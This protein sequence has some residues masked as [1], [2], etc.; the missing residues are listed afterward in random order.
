MGVFTSVKLAPSGQRQ[1]LESVFQARQTVRPVRRFIYRSEQLYAR[2]IANQIEILMQIGK[3]LPGPLLFCRREQY[4][5]SPNP[6][7]LPRLTRVAF[8]AIEVYGTAVRVGGRFRRSPNSGSK[9]RRDHGKLIPFLKETPG[10]APG[11]S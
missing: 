3:P 10:N 4:F 7:K 8:A 11:V 5:H 2:G 6:P 1:A 9:P